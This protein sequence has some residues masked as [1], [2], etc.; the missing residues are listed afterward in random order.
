MRIPGRRRRQSAGTATG[1]AG[2]APRRSRRLSPLRILVALGALSAVGAGGVAG[3]SRLVGTS[4]SQQGWFAGYVDATAT[5]RYA[6][7]NP[8]LSADRDVVLGF[9][10]ADPGHDCA[11]SWG[12][13]QTLDAASTALDLDRRIARLR[14]RGGD[15]VVSF[16]GAAHSELAA[17][18]T[19]QAALTAA[20][21]SVV[22]RY[23]L[24]TIDLDVEGAALAAPGAAQ[25]R[26][27]AVAVVQRRVRAAGGKLAVWLTLPVTPSG[28]DDN[29]FAVVQAM[30]AAHVDLA[31][32]NAMT[33]DFGSSRKGSSEL[34]AAESSLVELQRQLGVAYRRAG[35]RLSEQQLWTKVG[36]TPMLGQNDVAGERFSVADAVRL[37]GFARERGLGRLSVWSLN[38]DR[39]C[40]PNVPDTT[41]PQ[42]DCSGL[43]QKPG[44]F[45]VA[46]GRLPGRPS[47][48]AGRVTTNDAAPQAPDDPAT[49]PYPIWKSTGAYRQGSKIVWHHN[50][51][52]AKW[53]AQGEEP[54]APVLHSWETPWQLV[55]PVLP[56]EHPVTRPTLAPGT[57]PTW[58]PTATYVKG[59]RVMYH[60]L[61]YEA[62]WW[63]RGD[64]PSE[65]PAN[66][67][68]SPWQPVS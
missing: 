25:R 62:R 56:G 11:P 63:T 28:L 16:G 47:D 36:A 67:D 32:V 13:V 24:S 46:L 3:V 57:Y 61:G 66:A 68:S 22:D 8:A 6:F 2:A 18:C 51:Y 40:G 52:V 49:S 54:D 58:S 4:P 39:A 19:D 9:V 29:A 48:S 35:Q 43:E 59:R 44:A 14:Q 41:S 50:V 23:H 64:T 17:A 65:D 31:G 60:G 37:A 45:A 10:V 53:W 27:Q 21:S 42:D 30:L 38:R 15:V 12:A 5:P 7:E 34:A 1:E 33:M 26:A 55:G 20:Y